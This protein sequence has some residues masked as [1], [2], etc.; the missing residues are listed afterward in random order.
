MSAPE[1]E[2]EAAKLIVALVLAHP[3]LDRA[4]R[5]AQAGECRRETPVTLLRGATLIE[6]VVDLAFW[7]DDIWTVVDFKT[8]H[9]LAGG[10]A[11]YKRQVALYAEAISSATGTKAEAVL[12]RL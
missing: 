10:L 11:A 7:E 4:R 12:M 1:E 3:L 6:G 8:D 9:E 5:A 2:I